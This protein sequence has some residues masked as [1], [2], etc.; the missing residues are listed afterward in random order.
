MPS[1]RVRWFDA[2][3]GFGF[4]ASDEGTDV[5]LP[6]A[7]LPAGL[8][9]LRKNARVEFSVV[10]GR[11]G[12]QAMGVTLVATAPSMVKAN[13]PQADDM[14]AIVE[15]LIKLLDSAGNGLRRHHYPSAA[16]SKK[17]ATLLRAVA[18]N[19]DVQE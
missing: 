6:A 18:D 1:G 5:F 10:D 9:T 14:A 13:R 8:T 3:K 7:A 17:L 19:F 16:E 12:P 2:N 11:K 15:D 4:I